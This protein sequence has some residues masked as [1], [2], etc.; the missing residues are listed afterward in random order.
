MLP[1]NPTLSPQG[2]CLPGGPLSGSSLRTEHPLH[3]S[4]AGRRCLTTSSTAPQASEYREQRKPTG[5]AF[6]VGSLGTRAVSQACPI[7]D[8]PGP[9][10]SLGSPHPGPPGPQDISTALPQVW[11]E[12][13]PLDFCNFSAVAGLPSPGGPACSPLPCTSLGRLPHAGWLPWCPRGCR[14]RPAGLHSSPC[15]WSAV[16]CSQVRRVRLGRAGAGGLVEGGGS[17]RGRASPILLPGRGNTSL[18]SRLTRWPQ[19][20]TSSPQPPG[21]TGT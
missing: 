8:S 10:T 16:C 7:Q 3:P 11:A 6:P 13:Q 5:L 21:L 4:S 18:N 2:Q 12:E 14:Q 19:Q 15:F 9:S 17:G 20:N 1:C